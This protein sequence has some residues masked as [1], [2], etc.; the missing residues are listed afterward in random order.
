MRVLG[1]NLGADG[2]TFYITNAGDF[3]IYPRGRNWCV[4]HGDTLS[5]HDSRRDAIRW[6]DSKL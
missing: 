5:V 4:L 1:F 2:S 6:I 3:T